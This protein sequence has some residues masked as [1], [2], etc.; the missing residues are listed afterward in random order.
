VIVSATTLA[1]AVTPPAP[2]SQTIIRLFIGNTQYYVNNAPLSM[3][4]APV[5]QSGRTFLPIKYVADPIGAGLS[6]DAAAKKATITLD[7][8]V[9]ELW[10]GSNTA[11]VNGIPTLIDPMDASVTPFSLPPGRIMLPLRFIA[12]NL[13]CAVDWLGA[14]KEARVTYPAP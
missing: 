12:E 7:G 1:E 9:I 11:K 13:G 3:D 6:W 10:V 14:A 4:V 8:K 2:A 5:S